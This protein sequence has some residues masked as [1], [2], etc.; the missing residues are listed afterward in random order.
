MSPRGEAVAQHVEQLRVL[1][2]EHF[3]VFVQVPVAGDDRDV[4]VADQD[5]Y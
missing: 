1:G 4:G 2:N 3:G 5:R